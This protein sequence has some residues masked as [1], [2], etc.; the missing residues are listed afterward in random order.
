MNTIKRKKPWEN[1]RIAYSKTIVKFTL[2]INL[3]S[4]QLLEPIDYLEQFGQIAP[5]RQRVYKTVSNSILYML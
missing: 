4:L 1:G 5:R 3:E 2:P